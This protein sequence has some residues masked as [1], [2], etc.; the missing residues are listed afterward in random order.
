[1][2]Y[3]S[4]VKNIDNSRLY[5]ITDT[6]DGVEEFYS[7]N[8]ILKFAETLD[9]DGVDLHARQVFVVKLKSETIKLFKSG[10]IHLA[11]STMSLENSYYIKFK[12][13]PTSGEMSFVRNQGIN[14]SRRGINDFSFD[15]GTS[16]SYRSGLTLDDILTVLEGFSS[17]RIVDAGA[18]RI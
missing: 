9:I 5:G 2:Y 12:S 10:K 13:K 15:L 16:K 6:K 14:I 1:M 8:D 18:G 17:W 4:S 3:V 11:I 7:A